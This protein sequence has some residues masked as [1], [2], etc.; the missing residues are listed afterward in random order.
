MNHNTKIPTVTAVRLTRLGFAA[1]F[2]TELQ[3]DFSNDR[4]HAVEI[5]APY[6]ASSVVAALLI[7]ARNIQFDTEL[8]SL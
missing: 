4:H 5:E 6:D 3:I 7:A 1:G 8:K 2:R